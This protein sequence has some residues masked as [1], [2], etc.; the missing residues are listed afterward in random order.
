MIAVLNVLSVS[1]LYMYFTLGHIL[2]CIPWACTAPQCIWTSQTADIS[3]LAALMC[4]MKSLKFYVWA[5]L[6]IYDPIWKINVIGIFQYI[7]WRYDAFQ[8]CGIF[9]VLQRIHA[10]FTKFNLEAVTLKIIDKLHYKRCLSGLDKTIF[11]YSP[12]IK[13]L[14]IMK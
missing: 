9:E 7:P 13:E 2:Y 3:Q 14:S 6:C 1:I 5:F 8:C 12:E 11:L 4:V 10:P